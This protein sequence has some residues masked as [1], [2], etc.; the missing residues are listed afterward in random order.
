MC[1]QVLSKSVADAFAYFGDDATT[2]TETFVRNFDRFFDCLNVRSIS[3]WKTKRKEDLKPYKTADDSRLKVRS[4]CCIAFVLRILNM[5]TQK[6]NAMHMCNYLLQLLENDFLQY[7]KNWEDSVN[8]CTDLSKGK[9][10]KL[11][12]STETPEGLRITGVYKSDIAMH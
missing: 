11:L 5:N 10:Q 12:L 9:K 7:L 6:K 3:E 2:E 1:T 8:R 4:K